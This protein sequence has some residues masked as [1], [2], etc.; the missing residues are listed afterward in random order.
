MRRTGMRWLVQGR[1]D[2]LLLALKVLVALQQ[3]QQWC[4][5]HQLSTNP[6]LLHLLSLDEHC[7]HPYYYYC[8]LHQLSFHLHQLQTVP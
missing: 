2:S 6:V 3:Q 8:C 1:L 4:M 7:Y 5:W